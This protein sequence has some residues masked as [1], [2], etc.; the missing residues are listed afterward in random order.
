MHAGKVSLKVKF[1]RSVSAGAVKVNVSVEV[2][3]MSIVDG[4]KPFVTATPSVMVYTSTGAVA[5][6]VLNGPSNVVRP[7]TGMVLVYEASVAP[8]AVVTVAIKVQL[9]LAGIVPP[10]N[11]SVRSDGAP[12]RL[13]TPP[14]EQTGFGHANLL[15]TGR[16]V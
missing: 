15:C 1:V 10:V 14:Q 4:E 13:A 2:F 11:V 3:P 8:A 12:D 6:E 9:P 16:C 5:G 7:F